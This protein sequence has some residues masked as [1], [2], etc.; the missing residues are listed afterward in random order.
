M[1]RVTDASTVTNLPAPTSTGSPGFF[2]SG[3]PAAGQEATIVTQDWLNGVQEELIAVIEA[4]G[5]APNIANNE[6]ILAALQFFSGAYAVDS[7]TVNALA[8]SL[9][10]APTAYS[11]IIGMPLRV[12][13]AN[14]ITGAATLNVN[15][16]GPET[17][18]NPNGTNLVP[19]QLTV[20]GVYT[21]VYN[22]GVFVLQSISSSSIP[23]TLAPSAASTLTVAQNGALVALFGSATYATTLPSPIGD[24]GINYTFVNNS[25]VTQTLVAPAGSFTGPNGSGGQTLSL[26][27]GSSI[28]VMS[29]GTNWVTMDLTPVGGGK[30]INVQRFVANGI[31]TPT[32]G[33]QSIV[34]YVQ[35]AGGGSGGIPATSSTQTGISSAGTPGSW[36]K[37][38]YTSGFAG[39]AVT[40]GGGGLAG[41]STTAGSQGG[42]TSF[43]AL[44][45]CPGGP[46]SIAGSVSSNF[47]ISF[48]GGDSASPTGSGIILSGYGAQPPIALQ[49]GPGSATNV[50]NG[51]P[52]MYGGSVYG[53][54]ARGLYIPTSTAA[55]NGLSGGSGMI[56]IEEYA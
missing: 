36:A 45:S 24:G 10:P 51:N 28:F 1:Q 32:P 43:G 30:L 29:S 7:G 42:T 41:T 33:T 49:A 34:V 47:I 55:T 52:S 22:G 17:I 16:L 46:G 50:G 5:L 13:V 27:A 4:A 2:S 48:A 9:T 14:A 40:I 26:A 12:R 31:Y 11:Q 20:G 53:Y 15:G 38:R 39:L 8:I 25:S 56:I 18:Q 37:A 35:G 54:G 19:N 23:P 3:N 6:Q 21:L 44:L